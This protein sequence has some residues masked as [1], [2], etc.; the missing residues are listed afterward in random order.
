MTAPCSSRAGTA[1]TPT[2]R[3]R[4]RRRWLAETVPSSGSGRL[5]RRGRLPTAVVTSRPWGARGE[6]VRRRLAV[7]DG[8]RTVL[9]APTWRDDASFA[10]ELDVRALIDELGGDWFLLLRAH[11]VVADTVGAELGP[12]VT[13][14]SH[15]PD[16]RDL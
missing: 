4:S 1:A 15:Y 16:I 5:R 14:V 12:G 9:Y 3:G 2:T 11:K 10:L 7:P 6:A 13:N 8:V